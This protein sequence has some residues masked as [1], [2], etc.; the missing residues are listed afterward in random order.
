MHFMRDFKKTKGVKMFSMMLSNAG[1]KVVLAGGGGERYFSKK[2]SINVNSYNDGYKSVAIVLPNVTYPIK[3]IFVEYELFNMRTDFYPSK[4]TLELVA[5]LY[6][7]FEYHIG[8]SAHY[9]IPANVVLRKGSALINTNN[10]T[11]EIRMWSK[12]SNIKKPHARLKAT[13]YY[14]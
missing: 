4:K 13:I 14:D 8:Y 1:Y 6:G 10:T 5:V 7:G 2:T 9:K 3:E 12:A 11:Q